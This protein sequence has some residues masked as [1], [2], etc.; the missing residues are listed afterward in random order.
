MWI[1]V[2]GKVYIFVVEDRLYFLVGEIYV[3]LVRLMNVIKREGYILI[4]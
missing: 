4:I 3:E 2:V 1:E